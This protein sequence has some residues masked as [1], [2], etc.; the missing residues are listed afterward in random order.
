MIFF[1]LIIHVA[2]SILCT[3]FIYSLFKLDVLPSHSIHPFLNFSV[4]NVGE[5]RRFQEPQVSIA[6]MAMTSS[7]SSTYIDNRRAPVGMTVQMEEKYQPPSASSL[8][9]SRFRGRQV[10]FIFL[11]S[12]YMWGDG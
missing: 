7:P 9:E 8:Y 2:V 5:E 1:L 12:V 10:C 3:I 6:P 4:A 11:A